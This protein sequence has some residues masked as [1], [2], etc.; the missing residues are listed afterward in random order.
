MTTRIVVL[1][2]AVACVAIFLAIA[3]TVPVFQRSQPFD[4]S[5]TLPTGTASF[6]G[7][8]GCGP[9][10]TVRESFPSNG[11]VS[12]WITQNGSDGSVNIQGTY[13]SG[14]FFMSTGFGGISQGSFPGG[15]YTFVFQACGPTPT[16]SLGFWGVTNYSAP[17]L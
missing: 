6:N 17:L 3:S 8:S 15:A 9:N 4:L 14:S 7:Q 1:L 5:R 12:Y 13:A 16:V 2:V 11:I 10:E